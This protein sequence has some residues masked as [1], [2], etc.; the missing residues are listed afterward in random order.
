MGTYLE[1][2]IP[3]VFGKRVEKILQFE[4]G[5]SNPTYYFMDDKNNQFVLRKKPSGQLLPSAHAVEREYRVIKALAKTDVPVPP[6]YHLCTDHAVIGTP[7]YVMKYLQGR[8]LTDIALPQCS[9]SER[10]AIYQELISVLARIHNVGLAG[11]GLADFGPA[12]NYYERQIGRWTK[13]YEGSKTKEIPEMDKLIKWLPNNIPTQKETTLVHGDFRLGNVMFHPTE[14][15]IIAVLDWELSTLGHPY[16]DL[17]YLCLPYHTPAIATIPG[18]GNIN[19]EKLGIPVE[20]KIIE[21]YC[22]LRSLPKI[23]NWNYFIAFSLFRGAGIFQGIAKR[24]E[25]GNASSANA[26]AIG[27]ATALYAARGWEKAIQSDPFI[28]TQELFPF[29][30]KFAPL[31]KKLLEF[32]DEHV[33][34]NEET[35]AKQHN[36]LP[37][38]WAIPPIMEELKIKAKEAGLW[39]L[40]LPGVSGLTNLDY[41][42]L[43]EIMGRS[44]IA[45]EIFNCSAPDTGNMEVL[46]RYGSPEQKEKYL[47]P[48]L[49]GKIRSAFCM[50]EPEVASS[51]AS[52]IQTSIVR[53]DKGYLINGRK[54]W[55]SGAG[56]PRCSIFVLMGKTN[57][58]AP[59]HLRQSMILVE[60]DTPGVKILR[61]LSVFGY[62]DAPHGHSEIVFENVLVPLE[63]M[64]LGE[65]RGFEIAQGRLGPGRIHHCMRTIGTAERCLELMVRRIHQRRTFGK[66]IAEHGTIMQDVA[67]SRMEID[68]ARL[69][70]YRAAH[71]M[72]TMGNIVA[73]DQIA[74]IKAVVPQMALKVI[75]RAIQ[76]HGGAGVSSD[77]TLAY[78]YAG[79]R[80]LRLADGPDEVHERTVAQ[81]EYQKQFSKL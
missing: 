67:R 43:C 14:P 61:T 54:W 21:L 66:L 27:A 65:G 26:K 37:T 76:A 8:I 49:E 5:Q 40:W 10:T 33:Y 55:S 24:A 75:D 52:N 51:D 53:T 60:R 48:L 63:N 56:D 36:A 7:F 9:P 29:S 73:R 50:T 1:R 62:D 41:A 57:P 35:Y 64:I 18:F 32:M 13:Q 17:S 4:G 16:S 47:K 80:T 31:R 42:P 12:G 79:I 45:P 74:M 39:N 44:F 25:L 72:D 81:L 2:V 6:V 77:F 19:L 20:S 71:A 78:A 69:L 11:V 70:V 3:H 59:A 15:K 38:R 58:K 34:P 23:S 30:P 28:Q 68:Q 46:H 22:K